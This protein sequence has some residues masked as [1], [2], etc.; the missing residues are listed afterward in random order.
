MPMIVEGGWWQLIR[1]SFLLFLFFEAI[2]ICF[3]VNCVNSITERRVNSWGTADSCSRMAMVPV[4][5]LFCVLSFWLL[6]WELSQLSCYYSGTLGMQV[7]MCFTKRDM[8]DNFW[9]FY[10]KAA[11]N[12]CEPVPFA[13]QDWATHTAVACHCH[14]SRAVL[15]I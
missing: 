13:C 3:P 4:T 10:V 12:R 1:Y 6:Y 7:Y 5:F 14:Y 11:E 8:S 15:H 2:C 9:W